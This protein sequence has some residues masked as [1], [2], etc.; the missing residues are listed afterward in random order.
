MTTLQLF[1]SVFIVALGTVLVRALPFLLF[2]E[3]KKVPAFVL[4][5]GQMLPGAV[6]AMLVVY[7]LKDIT[8][9]QTPWGIP[10][11]AGV[12]ATAAV[13]IWKRKTILSV[14]TGTALYMILIRII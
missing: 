11:L 4:W 6:M 9:V 5:L 2:P 8:F 7:C 12:A 1:A 13:H 14:C 3:G 10:A